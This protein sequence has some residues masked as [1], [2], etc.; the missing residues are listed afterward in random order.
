MLR[1]YWGS[2]EGWKKS[3]GLGQQFSEHIYREVRDRPKPS[4]IPTGE[5]ALWRLLGASASKKMAPPVGLEESRPQE[6]ERRTWLRGEVCP[7]N[8]RTVDLAPEGTLPV[9]V[10]ETSMEVRE[11]M[12]NKGAKVI[13][14]TDRDD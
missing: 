5:D 2:E 13:H 6:K 10:V 12:S 3:A 7:L 8:V 4:G 9:N 1:D 11:A 14:Y